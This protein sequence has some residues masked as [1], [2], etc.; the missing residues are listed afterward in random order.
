MPPLAKTKRHLAIKTVLDADAVFARKLTGD[1]GMSRL[2]EYRID[3]YGEEADIT[4]SDMLGTNATVRLALPDDEMRYFNG[5]V[6]EIRFTGVDDHQWTH[7]ELVLVPW[8]WFLTRTADC[9]IFQNQD[10][11]QIIDTVLKEQGFSDYT[12]QLTETYPTHDY[13]VQYRETDFNFISRLMEEEGMFYFF[14]HEDGRHEMVIGDSASCHEP[15]LAHEEIPYTGSSGVAVA[16]DGITSWNPSEEL[17]PCAYTLNDFDFEAP[18][19]NLRAKANQSRE[20]AA[21][22]FEVYDYPGRYVDSG[23]GERRAKVRLQEEQCHYFSAQ[24]KGNSRALAAGYKFTLTDY[25]A[26]HEG[27]FV[28]TDT[29]LAISAEESDG[30]SMFSVEA[31]VIDA[32]AVFR[33]PRTARQPFMHG[34]QTA[35]VTGPAGEEIHTD[36]YGR[37]KVQFH[38]DREGKGDEN[39][40][41][42]I[43]VSQ[44]WAGKRWGAMFI[45][46]IGTEV[47]VDFLEGDPDRPIITGRVYNAATMPPYDLPAEKTKST[48]KTS[49]SKGGQGFNELRFEDKKG[50]E[51]I[52]IHAEK[53]EDVRVKNNAREWIGANRHLIVQGEQREQVVKDKHSLVKGDR[54]GKIEGDESRAVEGSQ[55][56]KV[57]DSVH[58]S[59]G[60]DLVEKT[61]GNLE[62]TVG[63]AENR[64]V[65]QTLS[66]TTGMDSLH[67]TGML[68]AVDAG[69]EVHI[70]AGM[71]VVIE[72]G[73]QLSLKGPGGF[74]DIGPAGVSIQGVMV[75]INSGGAAGSGS[76][77]SPKS[78]AAPEAL[79]VPEDPA[80]ADGAKAGGIG[81][82]RSNSVER[83]TVALDSA[84]VGA[85]TPAAAVLADAAENGTP[86]CEECARAAA[87]AE[88]AEAEEAEEQ[89][90]QEDQEEQAGEAGEAGAQQGQQAGE[91][92]GGEAP[93][94]AGGQAGAQQGQ[95]AGGPGGGQVPG[96]AGGQAGARQ[97]QRA[98]GPGGEQAPGQA[99]GQAGARQ[100]QQAGGQ[101]GSE[102]PGQAG[103]QAG[104]QQGQRAGGPGGGR[105]PGQAGGQA[106]A[107]QGQQ[108]GE[109]PEGGQK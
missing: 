84:A 44:N 109:Q 53:D 79:D 14:R 64:K 22:T 41:C 36:K 18:A 60:S 94:Q 97:A 102:A 40:S 31:R 45:P 63:G 30:R 88:E 74:I 34:P 77:C 65:G 99:G 87:E 24:A 90:D 33:P 51:Q 71:K 93:G 8:V 1:E 81:A 13:C 92:E 21:S 66:I 25:A 98:G 20:H 76:G 57:G 101:G 85:M 38:W 43:R 56:V 39:T 75:K 50:E 35:I 11:Q 6:R 58:R 108:A 27:S 80:V 32:E 19:K 55:F 83:P 91:Q 42:W 48:I 82:T 12:F 23:E 103:G 16:R 68:H 67:K 4:Y 78:P 86:F 7:H 105:A 47:I 73:L 95:R 107:Q 72:A 46:R 62:T 104:A 59:I 28:T 29:S 5:F 10:T 61:G 9:R 52:F 106:G 49:S 15:W 37:V 96:Q 3:V 2:F 54:I 69:M 89:G 17:L 100:A 26:P 70:K